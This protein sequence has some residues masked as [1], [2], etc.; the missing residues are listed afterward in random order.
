MDHSM[1]PDMAVCIRV[2]K[3]E[4]E[5][6]RSGL[7]SAGILDT[8]F[9]ISSD[10]DYLYIPITA[11][12][13]MDYPAVVTEQEERERR[14]RDYREAADVPDGLRELLP[15]SFDVVGD[16]AM[17]KIPPELLPYKEQIGNA[18]LLA[19][20]NLRSVFSDSGVK[21][22]FRIRDL[23]RIA[24]TGPSETVHREFGTRLYTD[25]ARVYFNP[26]LSSERA[27]IASEVKKGEIIIDMFGGVA[28]FGTVICR[29]SEP[30]AVYSVDLNPEAERYARMNA[31]RNGIKVLKPITG[32]SS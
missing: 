25:P 20:R 23:E 13:Y 8:R 11:D 21:G 29:L 18:M 31:E 14:I 3:A 10:G 19:G 5:S 27:R 6:V 1:M 2:P 32:D 28:P 24:G 7:I 15:S 9:R 30:A 17:I 12:S 26:R 22:E 16:I 4:G